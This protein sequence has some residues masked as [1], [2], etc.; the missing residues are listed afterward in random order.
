MRLLVMPLGQRAAKTLAGECWGKEVHRI[1]RLDGVP[2]I[3]ASDWLVVAV[4]ARDDGAVS[5]VS[6]ALSHWSAVG[7]GPAIVA[8]RPTVEDSE[9]PPIE[10]LAYR[11]R[12]C[13]LD[14][15]LSEGGLVGTIA[16]FSATLFC[17]GLVGF[18]PDDLV[19]HLKRPCAG[20]VLTSRFEPGAA[21]GKL[22]ASLR[23]GLSD[24]DRVLVVLHCA[25][26]IELLDINAACNAVWQAARPDAPILVACPLTTEA[27]MVV[28][29]L[30]MA[31]STP[32]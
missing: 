13:V 21:A 3:T 17:L 14:V 23:S 16:T 1:L 22:P 31:R 7:G 29:P 19:E 18:H 15:G 30:F 4:D 27:R 28:V 12:C 32:A 5:E 20:Q 10:D 25:D 11:W 6:E 24:A 8:V 2:A 26:T 9:L